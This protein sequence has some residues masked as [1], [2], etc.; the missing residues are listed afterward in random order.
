MKGYGKRSCC[1]FFWEKVKNKP[2]Y[3]LPIYLRVTINGKKLEVT[4]HQHVQPS[5]WSSEKERVKGETNTAI[6]INSSLDQLIKK[7][8]DYKEIIQKEQRN[9]SEE[10]T[11]ELQSQFHLVCRLL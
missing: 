9:R 6:Q 11:S 8:Y 5:E 4:T 1:A 7:V 10:H 2:T 3:L